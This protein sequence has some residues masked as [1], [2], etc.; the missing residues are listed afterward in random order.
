MGKTVADIAQEF[1]LSITTVRFIIGGNA[2]RY[3]ISA[4]TEKKVKDYIE[5]HGLIVNHAARSLKLKKTET[6][7]II[8]PR[9]SNPFFARL[10]ETFEAHCRSLGY[11][12]IFSCSQNNDKE[13]ANLIRMMLSRGVDGLFIA[14]NS[15]ESQQYAIQSVSKPI[16]FIDRDFGIGKLNSVITDNFGGG[17]QLAQAILKDNEHELIVFIGDESLP[18]IASRLAGIE[19]YCSEHLKKSFK[20]IKLKGNS[21]EYGQK[22]MQTYLKKNS[23]PRC[24]VTSSLNILEGCLYAA[25]NAKLVFNE[26]AIFGTFDYHPMLEFLNNE[27]WIV[28]QNRQELVQVAFEMMM[29]MLQS[30]QDEDISSTLQNNKTFSSNPCLINLNHK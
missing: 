19:K 24:M 29:N 10:I 18:T 25:K 17:Y 21:A 16:V 22:G 28:E 2:Q 13:E 1:N 27:L 14:C 9:L 23:L 11:Q 12:L 8:I 5:K 7:G 30:N 3:R 15:K 20:V 6:L 26:R 4:K